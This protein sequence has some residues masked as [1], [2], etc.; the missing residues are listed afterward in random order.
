MKNT[1]ITEEYDRGR[2]CTYCDC[3]IPKGERHIRFHHSVMMRGSLTVHMC[4]LC[5]RKAYNEI[6]P[7]QI[8]EMAKRRVLVEIQK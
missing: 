8:K 2:T 5:L 1:K 3:K 6:P 4:A 7:I